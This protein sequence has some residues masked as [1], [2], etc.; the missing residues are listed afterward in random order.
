M[1][2]WDPDFDVY[3]ARM[4]DAPASFVIDMAAAA[5]APLASHPLRVQTRVK[6]RQPLPD[7][8]RDASE[9]EPLGRVEDAIEARVTT[10]LEGV[11]VGRFLGE[12]YMTLVFYVGP[13]VDA[14]E[15]VLATTEPID[16][17]RVEWLTEGD[18]EWSFY[19]DVLFPDDA[20]R[21]GILNRRQIRERVSLGDRL[22]VAREVDHFAV[23]PSK[24]K[25]N[26]AA[27]ALRRAG[28][29][30]D[31]PSAHD[32]DGFGL[33]FHKS[34]TLDDGRPDEFCAEARALVEPYG[35]D[36]DGWGATVV[37]GEA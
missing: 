28:Y 33:E 20:S 29:R 31:D 30:V 6:L 10:L 27:A 35:G 3:L 37:K 4:N 14:V 18:P 11:Y 24:E 26:A 7:G 2:S 9:L 8:L 34:E 23:F 19:F 22:D 5:H 32:D 36:Y 1:R 21:E 13:N 16:G 12:G 25:A 15:R 17:Y